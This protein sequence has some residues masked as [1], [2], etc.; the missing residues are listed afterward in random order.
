MSKSETLRQSA[1]DTN[2]KRL[3]GLASRVQGLRDAK[4]QS[5]E[6]LSRLLEPLAKALAT[7][8]ADA[9]QVL[10]DIDSKARETGDDFKRQLDQASAR[11]N[12]ATTQANEAAVR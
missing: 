3:E 11:L 6:E 1:E 12:E 2:Q 4:V 10:I 8:S 9:G 7:L 5:A